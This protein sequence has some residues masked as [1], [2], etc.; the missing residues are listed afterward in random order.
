MGELLSS[1]ENS[2]D[3]ATTLVWENVNFV[4][5][6]E[7][8][9]HI[10]YSKTTGFKG[11]MIDIFEIKGNKN[12]PVSALKRLKRMFE[13]EEKCGLSRPVFSF[14]TGKNLTRSKLN[15]W[16]EIILQDFVDS[17]HKITGHSFRAGIP[18][19]LASFPNENT[20]RD[21]KQWGSWESNCFLKY[22]KQE[23]EKRRALFS[24]IVSCLYEY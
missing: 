8:L 13:K 6:N 19:T 14:K 2:F 3:S 20:I 10:P 5:S 18:S 23:R 11:K 16:L 21:I 15:K 17:N 24:R 1:H 4:D 12:C 22:T 7:V 9:I